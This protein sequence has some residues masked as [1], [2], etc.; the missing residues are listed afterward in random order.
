ML[1]QSLIQSEVSEVENKIKALD[2]IRE[3]LE[4]DLLKIQE[5]ELELDAERMSL[6]LA[7][8]QSAHHTSVQGIHERLQFEQATFKHHKVATP[9][10]NPVPP[11]RRRKGI[12]YPACTFTHISPVL[13]PAFL[14]SEH[15]DLPPAIA[16]MVS[17]IILFSVS[18]LTL[19]PRPW[20][21]IRH[22]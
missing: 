1:S 18:P 3:Q 21:A 4:R 10:M 11:S 5:D 14:P 13:G 16:F 12:R 9:Q 17:H 19:H 6:L 8:Y 15:D 2:L 7:S 20:R 22:L